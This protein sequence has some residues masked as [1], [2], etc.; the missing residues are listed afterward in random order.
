MLDGKRFLPATGMPMRNIDCISSPLA[1]AEPVPLTF[2]SFRAKSLIPVID[3]CDAKM[4]TSVIADTLRGARRSEG[5][6]TKREESSLR[7]TYNPLFGANKG[8]LI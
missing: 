2:A 5:H 3:C 8:I 6:L 4:A 1:L 7:W